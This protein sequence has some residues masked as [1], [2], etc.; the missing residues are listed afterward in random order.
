MKSPLSNI[1]KQVLDALS[2]MVVPDV[3]RTE[4]VHEL[5][6]C[7]IAFDYV[8]AECLIDGLIG[9]GYIRL[10][11]ACCHRVYGIRSP[12]GNPLRD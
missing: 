12:Q 11:D 10:V 4:L 2:D 1:Q 7:G 6:S 8:E 9:G 5:W 3:T